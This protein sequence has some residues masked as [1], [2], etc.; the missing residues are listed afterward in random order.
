[1][2][3]VLKKQKEKHNRKILIRELY[4][5][6][7]IILTIITFFTSCDYEAQLSY[8]VKNN[9]SGKIQIIVTN[10]DPLT[11]TD[12]FN[13]SKDKQETIAINGRGINGVDYYKENEETL[14]DFSQMDIFIADTVKSV[15]DFLKTSCWEYNETSKHSADY[16]LT[17]NNDDF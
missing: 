12:T 2:K 14:R 13:I 5:S 15:T 16:I 7:I 17:V 3:Y 6:T 4:F 9:T 10:L 1:M 8:I 11:K